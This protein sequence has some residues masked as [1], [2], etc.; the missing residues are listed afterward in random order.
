MSKTEKFLLEMLEGVRALDALGDASATYGELAAKI[1]VY[2]RSIGRHLDA[3][4]AVAKFARD[5]QIA[6]AVYRIT[7][8]RGEAGTGSARDMRI[9][10]ANAVRAAIGDEEIADLEEEAA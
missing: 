10:D 1:G 2:H 4:A 3:I 8:V 6:S 5:P 7:N 9:V